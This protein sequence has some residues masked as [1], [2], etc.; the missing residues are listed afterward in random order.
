MAA[1]LFNTALLAPEVKQRLSLLL[2]GGALLR[3][4]REQDVTQAYV[5]G[6][7]NPQ[8]SK[9][10]V[11]P[12]LQKQT[13]DSVR[14]YV[15]QAWHG[16]RDVLFGVMIDNALR[17]TIRLYEIDDQ[18]QAVMGI[19]LFD[20]SYWGQGWGSRC[21]RKVAEF[22]TQSLGLRRIVAGSYQANAGALRSF[23]KAG[24]IRTPERD[25]SDDYDRWITSAYE[26]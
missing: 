3:P 22:A 25:Y 4:L 7:N 2:D 9:Y 5:D 14:A 13:F 20:T 17:G 12:R 19:A 26:A 8:V 11:G 24:F 21:I 6:L 18:M 1:Y 16:E 23:A 15:R 10:L